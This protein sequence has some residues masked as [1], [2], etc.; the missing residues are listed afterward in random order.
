M[1]NYS[2]ILALLVLGALA[3]WIVRHGSSEKTRSLDAA[4]KSA[5]A[6]RP[7]DTKPLAA[8]APP[9]AAP[10]PVRA[11]RDSDESPPPP[12]AATKFTVTG[13]VVDGAGKPLASFS[14]EARPLNRRPEEYDD[15]FRL[16]K[17]SGRDGV[18]SLESL[19]S[20]EWALVAVGPGDTRSAPLVWR[21]PSK[22]A[23]PTLVVAAPVQL[24]GIVTG[25]GDAPVGGAEVFL[26]YA[27][28]R[29]PTPASMR[30]ESV[31][32]ARTD[33]NGRFSI[34]SV[35]PGRITLVASHHDYCNSDYSRL[36]L[37]PEGLPEVR[38]KLRQGAR[39]VGSVDPSMGSLSER[40]V[41]LYSFNGSIG[42]QATKTDATGRFEFVHVIPQDY[43]IELKTD[44]ATVVERDG[45]VHKASEASP[46]APKDKGVRLRIEAR[47]GETTRVVLGATRR[48]IHG[49]GRITSRGEPIVGAQVV[50][51][52]IEPREDLQQD[53]HSDGGGAFAIEIAGP[54]RYRLSVFWKSSEYDR[55]IEVP[56]GESVDLSLEV[57]SGGVFGRVVDP[58]GNAVAN[59]LVTLTDAER[60]AFVESGRP[61]GA[62]NRARSDKDGNFEIRFLSPGRYTLAAPDGN[63]FF[64][65]RAYEPYGR[66]FRRDLRIETE[67]EKDVE[68]KLAIE[69]RIT[70]R[71]TD[72]LG[73]SAGGAHLLVKDAE[74]RCCSTYWEETADEA[75][76]FLLRSLAPGTYRVVAW[77]D[78]LQGESA[79]VTVEA[80]QTTEAKVE[81]VSK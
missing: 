8:P 34:A 81:L 23:P 55:E 57:P 26:A 72:A 59:V 68:M 7:D 74:G 56:D 2:R 22:E 30:D 42:W 12:R 58:E 71:V 13:R 51:N 19:F 9:P 46:G 1:R 39:V 48:R 16:Q 32:C 67:I 53:V 11:R 6:E 5:P 38:L 80:D 65:P 61:R 24:D 4:P 25:E 47:E 41:H 79:P 37:P 45:T 52:S 70:G 20:G 63:Q 76:S 78:G 35:R 77:R 75:G 66:V 43:V 54:G 31:A 33:A 64:L 36:D 44:D 3:I 14:V 21:I 49:R 17:L 50:V 10:D 18:F 62:A 15:N 40:D 60:S 27:G 28:E 73:R 69:G 29:L